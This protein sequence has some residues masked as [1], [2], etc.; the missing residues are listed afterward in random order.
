MPASDIRDIDKEIEALDPET[1]KCV[2]NALPTVNREYKPP[3]IHRTKEGHPVFNICRAIFDDAL[4]KCG[5]G[6]GKRGSCCKI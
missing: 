5:V 3:Y 1:W 6:K 2:M 4:E